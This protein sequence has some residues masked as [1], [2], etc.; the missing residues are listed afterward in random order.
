VSSTLGA[1]VFTAPLSALYF[2]SLPLISPLSN[3]LCLP[4]A[5]LIFS[6]GLLSVIGGMICPPVGVVLSILPGL[7]IRFVL[8]TAECGM[9]NLCWIR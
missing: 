9:P 8:L 6:V 5:S 3:F 4:A 1:L 7:L 2:N